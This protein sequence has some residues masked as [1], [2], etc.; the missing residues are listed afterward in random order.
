MKYI[1]E[2]ETIGAFDILIAGG[3]PAGIAAAITAADMGMRTLLIERAGILGGNLTV[4]HVSPISGGH[5]NHTAACLIR[6]RI[7]GG[8]DTNHIEH[9]KIELMKLVKEKDICVYLNTSVCDVIREAGKIQSVLISSQSGLKNVC[10]SVFVDATGDGVLSYLAGEQTKF[11]RK[12]GLVQPMSVMFTISNVDKEQKL[13]CYA[14]NHKTLLKKGEY[15]ALC[16]KA[17]KN[18]ELPDSIDIVRLY[19]ADD[20]TE[21]MVN[22]TQVNGLNPLDKRDYFEAQVILRKQIEQVVDFLRNTVEGFGNIQLKDS[23]DVVGVR[24]SRRVVGQYTLTAEDLIASKKFK[25]VI[26]HNASFPID[27]HNPNGAGQAESNTIPVQIGK[28]DIPY[29]CIVPLENRNLFTAGRCIS[30]THRAHASYRVMNIAMN[31]GE[32]AGIAASLCVK[33]K[34]DNIS[35]SYKKVQSILLQKGIDLFD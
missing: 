10:A 13:M 14:E 35:L 30:G 9:A 22:A 4:G 5:V 28:Y 7:S 2:I 27:I 33:E 19:P 8:T 1:K 11:G 34:T 32:A 25:D 18:G 23:S 20:E 16:K 15:L 31:I 29:R 21:R 17:C 26:V 12:D 24:E 6:N 3:G